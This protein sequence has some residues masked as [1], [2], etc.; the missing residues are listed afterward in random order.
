[1]N[2]L[3][4]QNAKTIKGESLGWRTAILY[5]APHKISGTN[6]CEGA[7]PGCIASCLFTAGRGAMNYV[8]N[9]RLNKTNY[10][11]KDPKAFVEQLCGE[12]KREE[13]SAKKQGL[14]LCVRLNGTSDIR[15]ENHGII[16]QF[17]H[18]QFYDYTKIHE[19]VLNNKLAN[20]HLTFSLHEKNQDKALEVL[21][22]G[23]N[24]AAVF[25]NVLPEQYLGYPVTNGDEHDLRFTDISP[26]IVGLKAKGRARYDEIGF[27]LTTKEITNV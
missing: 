5:L 14:N 2:L 17:P 11:N 25:D 27:K 13:K 1:M 6:L 9:A 4:F 26:C 20:Y 19:R 12:I 24:V 10:F 3:T 23:Y 8:Q 16:Q 15:W 7:S 18:I 22:A 21:K